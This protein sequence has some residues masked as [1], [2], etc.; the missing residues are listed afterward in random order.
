MIA[1]CRRVG[2]V[3]AHPVV[4]PRSIRGNL[5]YGWEVMGEKRR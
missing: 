3:F 5:T 2:L 4:A 1:V